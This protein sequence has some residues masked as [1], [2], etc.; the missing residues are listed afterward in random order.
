M[1]LQ[2]G[3]RIRL[4]TMASV[5]DFES[6]EEEYEDPP[7]KATGTLAV[8]DPDEEKVTRNKHE[9]PA[10]GIDV[11]A[12]AGPAPRAPAPEDAKEE[13]KRINII[14]SGLINGDRDRLI[15]WRYTDSVNPRRVLSADV[16]DRM[17][18][19]ALKTAR[20]RFAVMASDE[21][22]AGIGGR[23]AEA[24][25]E[26]IQKKETSDQLRGRFDEE[27]KRRGVAAG[28]GSDQFETAVNLAVAV[29]ANEK[30][31]EDRAEM[32]QLVAKSLAAK[33]QTE[34]KKEAEKTRQG[35]AIEAVKREMREWLRQE[36]CLAVREDFWLVMSRKN[37]AALEA[38]CANPEMVT[39][40]CARQ[41]TMDSVVRDRAHGND[42]FS[43]EAQRMRYAAGVGGMPGA[44]RPV[45]VHG[46]AIPRRPPS[47]VVIPGFPG[48]GGGH[49]PARRAA[50]VAP[51]DRL[52]KARAWSFGDAPSSTPPHAPGAPMPEAVAAGPARRPAATDHD[53]DHF[54]INLT[55]PR[56]GVVLSLIQAGMLGAE[57]VY[58]SEKAPVQIVT[59]A[60]PVDTEALNEQIRLAE[61][62]VDAAGVT[63]VVIV[64]AQETYKKNAFTDVAGVLV[65]T[66]ENYTFEYVTGDG[67][68]HGE[69][70]ETTKGRIMDLIRNF[71][72]VKADDYKGVDKI[73]TGQRAGGAAHPAKVPT[74]AESLGLDP[75]RHRGKTITVSFAYQ[76]REVSNDPRPGVRREEQKRIDEIFE[77]ER[78]KESDIASILDAALRKVGV[79][80]RVL[81]G[82]IETRNSAALRIA[83]SGIGN[84]DRGG[85]YDADVEM[86]RLV[87]LG[88][89]PNFLCYFT[90]STGT[91]SSAKLPTHVNVLDGIEVFNAAL[92][93][94]FLTKWTG[95]Y[96]NSPVDAS[97][98]GE[99]AS[100]Q[101]IGKLVSVV[102]NILDG[103]KD[104]KLLFQ[105]PEPKRPPRKEQVKSSASAAAAAR[106]AKSPQAPEKK[107][108]VVSTDRMLGNR[109]RSEFI[110]GAIKR[111]LKADEQLFVAEGFSDFHIEI[112][113]YDP[114]REQRERNTAQIERAIKKQQEA[115]SYSELVFVWVQYVGTAGHK[116]YTF[117]DSL[118][119][120]FQMSFSTGSPKSWYTIRQK[121]D[122]TLED[123]GPDSDTFDK[124]VAQLRREYPKGVTNFPDA[125]EYTGPAPPSAAAAPGASADET[126]AAKPVGHKGFGS[127][128]DFFTRDMMMSKMSVIYT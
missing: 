38:A 62:G 65:S 27:L 95:G 4:C 84:A 9:V 69:A 97:V 17:F 39:R 109:E 88:F 47:S 99:N 30:R 103:A 36:R 68:A 123:T 28:G 90:T 124:I 19:A 16:I 66:R 70:N 86:G 2:P 117:D 58:P 87:S 41:V 3:T 26:G 53:P 61:A 35:G 81:D 80:V 105:R 76:D 12:P 52:G 56:R 102:L 10:P 113:V 51:R 45:H 125:K 112:C 55:G 14:V 121:V 59:C 96:K 127:S 104:L 67:L 54:A 71:G 57:T 116:K 29:R 50:Y 5:E 33:R 1:H 94:T 106:P 8:M 23:M 64:Q 32:Q 77:A 82:S 100:P 37:R 110:L 6:G 78:S 72:K 119:M 63:L 31:E 18:N 46:P 20:A 25:L 24:V 11:G 115:R 60:A 73:A 7:A 74:L 83:T 114:D 101:R 120:Q 42:L 44:A 48:R 22:T 21:R 43:P 13:E 85:V 122:D 34:A 49:A 15:R 91:G 89:R 126:S 108:Y 75:N 98:I 79:S 111:R 128:V 107:R 40:A 92:T 93:V 118:L